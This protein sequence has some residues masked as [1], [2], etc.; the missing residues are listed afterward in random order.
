[1]A[2]SGLLNIN[3][4]KVKI[5]SCYL[6]AFQI[7]KLNYEGNFTKVEKV[8]SLPSNTLFTKIRAVDSSAG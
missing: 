3:L 7:I 6:V 1:M 8:Y 5:I 4:P 2:D